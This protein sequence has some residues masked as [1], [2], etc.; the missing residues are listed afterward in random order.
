MTP[1]PQG[2]RTVGHLLAELGYDTAAFGKMH[3]HSPSHHGFAERIDAEDWLAEVRKT[4]PGFRDLGANLRPLKDPATKW[5][6]ADCKPVDLP[7]TQMEARFFADHAANYFAKPRDRPFALVVGFYE[8]HCPFPFP[9]EW[10]G[11]YRPD[12]F[13]V[14][15]VNEA[16]LRD[17]PKVFTK[18]SDDNTRSIQAAYFTSLS[19]LDAQI[20]R[21]LDSLEASGK[22]KDTIVIYLGDNG[23]LLGQHA[24]FE[25]HCFYEQAVRVPLIVRWPGHVREGLETKEMVELLDVAPTIFE[26]IGA[27]MPGDFQGRSLAPLLRGDAGAVGRDV[28]FSEYLE[29][30]EAM[31]RSDRFKLIVGTGAHARKDGYETEITANGPYQKLYDLEVDPGETTNCIDR[32]EFR[33]VVDELK[34]RMAARLLAGRPRVGNLPIDEIIH[35]GLIPPDK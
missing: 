8:P 16:D 5:L 27:A 21:V 12:D 34:R 29:T 24:R 28:V 25:K 35:R 32:A 10:A 6:N 4:R 3:F 2:T 20:G 1:L 11:R 26:L 18:L 33:P 31:V 7:E 19:F 13:L 30:E 15:P 22:A 9:K 23:Y 17:R 14:P